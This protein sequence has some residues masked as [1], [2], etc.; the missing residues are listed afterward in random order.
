MFYWVREVL[1]Y[2]LFVVLRYAL[3]GK[4]FLNERQKWIDDIHREHS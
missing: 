4:D 1:K 3:K 2:D